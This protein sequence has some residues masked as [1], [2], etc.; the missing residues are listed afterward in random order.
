M[1]PRCCLQGQVCVQCVGAGWGILRLPAGPTGRVTVCRS[2]CLFTLDDLHTRRPQS[3]SS[4]GRQPQ[5][6]RDWKLSTCVSVSTEG[7]ASGFQLA[8][9]EGMSAIGL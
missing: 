7:A 2:V 3:L 5:F 6:V 4:S 1:T 9:Q 8:L